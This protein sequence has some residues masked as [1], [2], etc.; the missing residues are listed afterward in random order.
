MP[1]TID[2][3]TSNRNSGPGLN[4]CHPCSIAALIAVATVRGRTAP[5]GRPRSLLGCAHG[6]DTNSR[7]PCPSAC[8]TAKH[9]GDHPIAWQYVGRPRTFHR[10]S[11]S[12]TMIRRDPF[13]ASATESPPRRHLLEDP[14]AG[15]PDDPLNRESVSTG[16]PWEPPWE[17][18]GRMI[19][20]RGEPIRT[21]RRSSA[22]H[23]DRFGRRQ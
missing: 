11:T 21:E 7:A 4:G 12:P 6:T 2:A 13:R 10:N 18:R 9:N 15:V 1:S 8:C 14:K 3:S 23:A 19:L 17:P 20:D 22:R 5:A 16:A